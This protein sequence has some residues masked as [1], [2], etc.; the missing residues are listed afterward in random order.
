MTDVGSATNTKEAQSRNMTNICTKYGFNC[1]IIVAVYQLMSVCACVCVSVCVHDNSKYNA[2]IHFKLEH[3][4][5]CEHSSDEFDTGHC[6][7]K[8]KATA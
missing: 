6:L 7:I 3:I 5:V 2:L 4:V 8:A 1:L